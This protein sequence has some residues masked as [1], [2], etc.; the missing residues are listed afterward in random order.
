MSSQQ[1]SNEPVTPELRDRNAAWI[2]QQFAGQTPPAEPAA[3]AASPEPA[4]APAPAPVTPP[5]PAPQFQQTPPAPL[6]SNASPSYLPP[7]D[8]EETRLQ[9]TFEQTFGGDPKRV[10]KSYV[11]AQRQATQANTVLSQ[12]NALGERDPKYKEVVNAM[13]KGE[14]LDNIRNLLGGPAE[15]AKPAGQSP[16]VPVG[17]QGQSNDTLE[18]TLVKEGL[19]NPNQ[20]AWVTPAEWQLKISDAL[21]ERTARMSLQRQ[22]ELTQQAQAEMEQRRIEQENKNRF[23][24]SFMSVVEDTG[25]DFAGK[26]AHLYQEIQ[27]TAVAYRDP[28]NLDMIAPDAFYKATIDVLR[29]KNL[30]IPENA[31][32]RFTTP[33]QQQQ[34]QPPQFGSRPAMPTASGPKSVADL[35]HEKR[36]KEYNERRDSMFSNRKF[37]EKRQ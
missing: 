10:V 31:M 1:T 29:A 26:D 19:L 33:V 37:L 22:Q 12:L 8:D 35:A 18:Q 24:T 25:L 23:Q 30:P 11:E 13:M 28:Q 2:A 32:R 20:K 7:V 34:P 15:P 17:P 3:P 16:T 14:P 5:A 4:P 21:A 27:R 6:A 9:R 36:L